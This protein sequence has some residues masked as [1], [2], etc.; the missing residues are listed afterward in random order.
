MWK[1]EFCFSWEK[2]R[3]C[4]AQ[5][6]ACVCTRV[7]KDKGTWLTLDG[8]CPRRPYLI[9]QN[10][11][12]KMG[13]SLVCAFLLKPYKWNLAMHGSY[14]YTS[15]TQP[16]QQRAVGKAKQDFK[17]NNNWDRRRGLPPPPGGNSLECVRQFTSSWCFL[18]K[19][20]KCQERANPGAR[21]N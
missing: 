19:P 10:F 15:E 20:D 11:S 5:N 14:F 17:N 18:S 12:Q 3:L 13:N 21:C 7:P 6:G 9:T 2:N 1:W 4:K 16:S 8:T